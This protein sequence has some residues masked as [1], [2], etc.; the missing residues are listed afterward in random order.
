MEVQEA[1]RLIEKGVDK[2]SS[3]WADLGAGSGIFTQALNEILG[4]NGVIFAVDQKLDIL[5][6]VLKTQYVRSKVHL[7]EENFTHPMPFLPS[8]DGHPC[9]A[10]TAALVARSARSPIRVTAPNI[11]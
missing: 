11:Q 4:F 5:R 8:L 1:M 2:Q 3:I 7:Y 6:D 10:N 9:Q